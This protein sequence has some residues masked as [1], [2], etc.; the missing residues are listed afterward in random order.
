MNTQQNLSPSR[1]VGNPRVILY[2]DGS[3]GFC[4]RCVLFLH[5]FGFSGEIKRHPKSDSLESILISVDGVLYEKSLAVLEALWFSKLWFLYVF[6]LVPPCL[7]NVMYDVVARYRK[8][9]CK[10]DPRLAK[11]L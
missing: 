10:Y 4:Q 7:R 8:N 11:L 6:Y 9:V 3:C 5:Q 1:T 2:Y